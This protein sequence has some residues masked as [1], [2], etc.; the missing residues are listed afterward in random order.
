MSEFPP[1]SNA[2]FDA[3]ATAMR[4]TERGRNF[5]DEFARREHAGEHAELRDAMGQLETAIAREMARFAE[6]PPLVPAEEPCASAEELKA[7]IGHAVDELGGIVAVT[8]S[9]VAETLKAAKQARALAARAKP[10]DTRLATDLADLAATIEACGLR[11]QVGNGVREVFDVLDE[12]RAHLDR[13]NGP[14][15]HAAPGA[16]APPHLRVVADNDA[17]PR[18][19]SRLRALSEEERIAFFT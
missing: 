4:S 15:L 3:I 6:A 16:K 2:E 18:A 5:L 14:P 7:R 17:K 1:S 9:T 12:V 10:A 11:A 8:T 19:S 13:R